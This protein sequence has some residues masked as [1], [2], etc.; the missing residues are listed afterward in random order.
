MAYDSG[1]KEKAFAILESYFKEHKSAEGHFLVNKVFGI[2][3]A[4]RGQD[5]KAV[6]FLAYAL[7]FMPDD[8]ECL[9]ALKGCYESQGDKRKAAVVNEVLGLLH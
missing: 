5:G 2:L 3:L 1:Q 4:E 8:T 6:P 9:G 7:Q